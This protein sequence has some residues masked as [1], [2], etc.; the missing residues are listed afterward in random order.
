MVSLI[1]VRS[2]APDQY[3]AQSL[4][5]PE[6]RATAATEA[7]AIDQV[8]ASLTSLLTSSKLVR[9]EV[10]LPDGGNPWLSGFGRSADD[11]DFDDYLREI[12]RARSTDDTE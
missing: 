6:V 9:V 11:P 3:V 8:R 12:Q 2:D 10:A 7:E 5:L 4:A 1:L